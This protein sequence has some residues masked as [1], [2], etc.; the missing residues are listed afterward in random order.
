VVHA[1]LP[2]DAVCAAAASGPALIPWE[3][4]RARPLGAT[5]RALGPISTLGL[6]IGPE[7]GFTE[8]EIAAAT[9]A[10][11]APVTLGRR[12]LRAE[13]AAAVATALALAALGEMD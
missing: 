10:G 9:A 8:A 12:I 3:G 6:F 4:E 2:F 1:P 7:G 5:V 11:I 13:T